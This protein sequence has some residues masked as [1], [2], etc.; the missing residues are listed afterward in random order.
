MSNSSL[1]N[2]VKISPNRTSPR[3]N[4][5]T[6]ITIHHMAGNLSVETCGNVF[7]PR[8]RQAS[9]NYGIDFVLIHKIDIQSCKTFESYMQCTYI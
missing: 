2:Y 1:V 4:K 6:K 8:S 9:S 3:R 7:A 5:I